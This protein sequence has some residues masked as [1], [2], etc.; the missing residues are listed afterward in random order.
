MKDITLQATATVTDE[1]FDILAISEGEAKG[2]GIRFASAVLQ[3]ALPLYQNKPVF[4]DHAGLFEAPSVRNL[5][6]TLTVS[7]WNDGERGIQSKLIPAGPAADV[8]LAV[9]DA[10]KTNPAI[11][12][13]VGFSTVL[14]V[15]LAQNGEV[16]KIVHVKS[17]DVV[18]DPARGGKFLSAVQGQKGEP[19]SEETTTQSA[20]LSVEQTAALELQGANDILADLKQKQQESNALQIEQCRNLLESALSASKLPAAAQRAVRKPFDKM[21]AENRPFLATALQEAITEKREELAELTSADNVH[22]PAR[23]NIGGMM[24]SA[25]Q[26]QAAVDDLLGAERDP[27]AENLK[28]A[29]LSGIREAYVLA[30]GDRDFFGGYF[31][32][33]KSTRLNSSHTPS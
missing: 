8:L 16:Q 27:G 24:N 18:I 33:R 25:D 12:E 32:D 1:G 17:V 19:M 11:M 13:A 2:H 28:V 5:A 10:A 22:G 15:K 29:R 31:P 9:R 14:R 23:V 30:T 6:G 3:E 21:L 20:T 7:A 4:I 26:L